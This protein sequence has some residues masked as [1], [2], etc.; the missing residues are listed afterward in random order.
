MTATEIIA[1]LPY[2]VPFLFVDGIDEISELGVTG[3]YTFRKK[4]FFYEGHFKNNPVTPGV[5]LTECMAQ[6]GLVC[7]GIFLIKDELD[8]SRKPQIALT[9]HQMD[10]YLPVLPGQKVIVRSEKE[11][12]RFNKLKCKVSMFN[13]KGDMVA[14]GSISGMLKA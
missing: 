8:L 6:I 4:A 10:F 5:I 13:S 2:E 3:H 1:L 7:L 12:F 9:S 14:R 11:V